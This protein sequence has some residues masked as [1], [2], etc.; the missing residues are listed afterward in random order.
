[1][2]PAPSRKASTQIVHPSTPRSERESASKHSRTVGSSPVIV[3]GLDWEIDDVFGGG[4]SSLSRGANYTAQQGP[5]KRKAKPSVTTAVVPAVHGGNTSCTDIKDL[6][7]L[8]PKGRPIRFARENQRQY[9]EVD[10]MELM[11]QVGS[12]YKPQT[13]DLMGGDLR[14]EEETDTVA[15]TCALVTEDQPR[16]GRAMSLSSCGVADISG[17][18]GSQWRGSSDPLYGRIADNGETAVG[19]LG[20]EDH[21]VSSGAKDTTI[22]RGID[23]QTQGEPSAHDVTE[24]NRNGRW[25][26]RGSHTA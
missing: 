13:V 6:F 14:A 21:E 2:N 19:G 5:S 25:E 9:S 11:R 15:T 8:P 10:D 16:E 3:F 26:A 22:H 1:M 23:I 17:R 18:Y 20:G 4:D 7:R 24:S 12:P